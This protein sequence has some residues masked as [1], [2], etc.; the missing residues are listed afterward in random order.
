MSLIK[1][2]LT[3]KLTVYGERVQLSLLGIDSLIMTPSRIIG[4]NN[5]GKIFFDVDKAFDNIL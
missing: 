2:I 1:L 4:S 5:D 3:E